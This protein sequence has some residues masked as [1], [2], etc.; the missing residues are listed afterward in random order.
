[1][2]YELFIICNTSSF[3][4]QANEIFYKKFETSVSSLYK[5]NDNFSH[6]KK[7]HKVLNTFTTVS[8]REESILLNIQ[9]KNDKQET[10]NK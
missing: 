6:I 9:L 1:V 2:D 3:K 8:G 7:Q 10:S 4:I 5:F